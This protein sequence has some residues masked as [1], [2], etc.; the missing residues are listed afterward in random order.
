M[1]G[2]N[3]LETVP[4]GITLYY[5][6]SAEL[7]FRN[8]SDLN[9][10]ISDLR[11]DWV[12]H[13]A[14]VVGGIQANIKEPYR[15]LTE[16]LY[17]NVNLVEACRINSVKNL[18]NL[19]SSCVYPANL[20]RPYV[21]SDLLNGK[22][23]ETNEGYA[24]AKLAALKQVSYLRNTGDFNYSTLIPC[25]LYGRYDSFH[26]EKSHLVPAIIAKVA[27]AK[28][29]GAKE[30]EIWGS[31][32]AR[33][34]FLYTG[35]LAEYIWYAIKNGVNLPSEMNV[36]LGHDFSI[37]EYYDAVQ[38]IMGTSLEYKFLLDKPEG[39]KSKLVN[40][41]LAKKY[42]WKAHTSLLEGLKR[43]I[44]FYNDEI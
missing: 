13:C 8:L 22:L 25:N 39:M 37:L 36:G 33:R 30:V 2:R 9:K 43:T 38:E 7:D 29:L 15:Y 31:G 28:L 12:I 20:G 32:M 34:E 21:E 41:E 5:P 40:I 17:I 11:P 42:N 10:Y 24:L 35:D 19:S 18:I 44:N 23:E 6:T 4:N 26:P 16:N 14:S 3:L 1:V 27:K